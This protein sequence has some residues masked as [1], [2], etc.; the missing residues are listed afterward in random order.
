MTIK[1]R[2]YNWQHRVKKGKAKGDKNVGIIGN[3]IVKYDWKK[4]ITFT[5]RIFK[6]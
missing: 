4:P 1:N 5:T 2:I 6:L 3:R